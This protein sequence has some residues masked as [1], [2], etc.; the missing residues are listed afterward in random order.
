MHAE[1]FMLRILIII[2]ALMG[3]ATAFPAFPQAP[4]PTVMEK[5][6]AGREASA[7]TPTPLVAEESLTVHGASPQT[8]S[9]TSLGPRDFTETI[10][11][12]PTMTL[13]IGESK[14][15]LDLPTETLGWLP[16]VTIAFEPTETIEFS[17]GSTYIIAPT[18]TTWPLITTVVPVTSTISGAKA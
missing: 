1:T 3:I 15:Q 11:L 9:P 14:S 13:I 18:E 4:A 7:Q 5:F 16:G 17:G 10:P 2:L 8:P 6:L 12:G